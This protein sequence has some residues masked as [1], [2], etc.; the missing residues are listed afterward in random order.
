MKSKIYSVEGR[1]A[2]EVIT[3]IQGMWCWF[4]RLEEGRTGPEERSEKK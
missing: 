2:V 1:A 3:D 4:A